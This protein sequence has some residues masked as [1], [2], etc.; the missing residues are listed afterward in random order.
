MMNSISS[1]RGGAPSRARQRLLR[2]E[3]P[4]EPQVAAVR[5]PI[6]EIGDDAGLELR[7]CANAT[8]TA[9]MPAR[10]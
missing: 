4:V 6:G 5:Q 9:P 10:P 3:Q 8:H 2:D 7:S 1:C